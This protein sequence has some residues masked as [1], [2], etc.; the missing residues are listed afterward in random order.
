MADVRNCDDQAKTVAV[1]FTVNSVVEIPRV[2]TIDRNKRQATQILPPFGLGRVDS[3]S[4]RMGLTQ[5]GSRKLVRQIEARNRGL[6][7]QLYRSIRI[8]PL[9]YARLRR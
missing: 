3:I 7:R 4:P 1:R 2:F 6:R 9:F 5:R 8:Q